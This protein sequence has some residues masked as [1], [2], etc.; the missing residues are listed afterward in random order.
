MVNIQKYVQNTECLAQ[1]VFK[2]YNSDFSYEERH[3]MIKKTLEAYKESR[4]DAFP[5]DELADF[6]SQEIIKYDAGLRDYK[7]DRW[8]VR[9]GTNFSVFILDEFRE[10][11][12]HPAWDDACK[13]VQMFFIVF[14][15][16]LRA[17]GRA[18]KIEQVPHVSYMKTMV[19]ELGLGETNSD[20]GKAIPA[21]LCTDEAKALL[22]KAIDNGL[23]D[24]DFSPTELVKTV[25]QKALL[26]DIISDKAGIKPKW[27]PFETLWGVKGLAQ[28]RYHSVE[29]VGKVKGE[30]PIL[31]AF[32]DR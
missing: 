1:C 8:L 2:I 17:A 23:L 10:D 5:Y 19:E 27:K 28:Q 6:F 16:V 4:L 14:S 22:Q 3:S 11:I 18:D 24:F 26:A 29:V 15:E 25:A 12:E 31:K 7:I 20:G 13:S 32:G 21:E 9:L 30:K